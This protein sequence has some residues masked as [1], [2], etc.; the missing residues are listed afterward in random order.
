MVA[1]MQPE[2][3]NP[4]P[5]SILIVDDT[6]ANLQLLAEMLKEQGYRIRAALSG[7]LA[8]AAIRKEPPDLILLDINMPG[9]NGFEIC[10]EIK[11]DEALKDIAII[12]VSAL[13]ETMDKVNA[14]S[15]GGVDYVTKPFQIEEVAARVQTHLEL[16]RQRRELQETYG[17]LRDLEEL[18]DNLVH[19]I[20]HDMRNPLLT[21]HACMELIRNREAENL[22]P[23]GRECVDE[24]LY[25]VGMLMEMIHSILDVSK[26]ETEQIPLTLTEFNVTG[27]I[28][29]VISKNESLK[30]SRVILLEGEHHPI[31]IIADKGLIGR[32]VE[33]LLDNA[34]AYTSETSGRIHFRIESDDTTIRVSIEDNGQGIPPD[35]HEKI[36]EKFFQVKGVLRGQRHSTGLG[37]TFCK[38]AVK[39]HG[40]RIGVISEENRGSMFWFE[41]PI[42]GPQPCT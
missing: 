24:A 25:S 6:P 34:L 3:V 18:R 42:H 17:R 41:L 33:N 16:R 30:K 22:S 37:L 20:I 40:G 29:D 27:L 8:L 32:V 13:N 36:I 2:V 38:L 28:E 26:M 9:M 35:L 4:N 14:F 5:P 12:F 39:A 21:T 23:S 15:L 1:A 11:A 19:M 7:K 31:P 10:K